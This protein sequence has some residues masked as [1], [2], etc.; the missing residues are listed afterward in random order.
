MHL[1][2]QISID[3]PQWLFIIYPTWF[4]RFLSFDFSNV[5]H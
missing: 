1:A 4:P 3:L 5:H 2:S